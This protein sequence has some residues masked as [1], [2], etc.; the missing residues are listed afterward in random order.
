M[1]GSCPL[2]ARTLT[3]G[4][5]LC[6]RELNKAEGG[7]VPQSGHPNHLHS[8]RA[9]SIPLSLSRCCHLCYSAD[10]IKIPNTR[11]LVP[12]SHF[13]RP[14]KLCPPPLSFDRLQ[15]SCVVPSGRSSTY[16]LLSSALSGSLTQGIAWAQPATEAFLCQTSHHHPAQ[17]SF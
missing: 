7:C 9:P 16:C 15:L 2:K 13:N 3:G 8:Q 10:K 1:E 4:G 11:S 14:L 6:H 12:I 5:N 17:A